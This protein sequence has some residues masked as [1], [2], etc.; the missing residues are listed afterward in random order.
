VTNEEQSTGRE[1]STEILRLQGEWEQADRE[2]VAA[3]ESGD[4]EAVQRLRYKV[5]ALMYDIAALR[6]DL[7]VEQVPAEGRQPGS[8]PGWFGMTESPRRDGPR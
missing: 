3:M 2:L 8:G 5:S 4:R 7:M 1:K 6:F